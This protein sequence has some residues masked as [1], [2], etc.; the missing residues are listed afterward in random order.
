[1][2]RTPIKRKTPLK[3]R[4]RTVWRGIV[5]PKRERV[6]ISKLCPKCECRECADCT[7]CVEHEA[8]RRKKRPKKKTK[9]ARRPRAPE[10]WWLFVKSGPCFVAV[11]HRLFEIDPISAVKLRRT[12]CGGVI[13]ADHMGD[14]MTQGDGT[15]ALDSTCVS[16][17]H[18]HHMERHGNTGAFKDFAREDMRAFT[19][20]G[21]QW[22]HNRAREVGIAIPDC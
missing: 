10:S 8:E 3:S 14:R 2:K 16:I 22:T 1:M 11:L 15:R 13:D 12:P 18:D 7:C 5:P 21:V 6:P 20:T 19:A 9:H 4:V 17:C